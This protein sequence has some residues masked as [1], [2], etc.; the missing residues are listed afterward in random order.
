MIFID[1]YEFLLIFYGFQRFLKLVL[2]MNNPTLR[3]IVSQRPTNSKKISFDVEFSMGRLINKEIEGLIALE[4][5]KKDL[6]FN[7]AD[8]DLK[9]AFFTID[10]T[11]CGFLTFDILQVFFEDQGLFYSQEQIVSL[12][13][14]LD[15]NDDGKASFDEFRFAIFPLDGTV[16]K[17]T[18]PGFNYDKNLEKSVNYDHEREKYLNESEMILE[19]QKSKKKTL[20]KSF[21]LDDRNL[22]RSLKNDNKSFVSESQFT[23][24]CCHKEKEPVLHTD[25]SRFC[26]KHAKPKQDFSQFHF[27]EQG[28]LARTLKQFILL[29]KEVEIMRRD[30][31]IRE[32][33]E[34]L[35]A[36]QIMDYKGKGSLS[37]YE[38]EEA[39]NKLKVFPGKYELFLFIKRFNREVDGKLSFA[40]FV[41]SMVP[42]ELRAIVGKRRPIDENATFDDFSEVFSHDFSFIFS[43]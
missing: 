14:R 29:D 3:T 41:E 35:T 12:L 6:F 10:K 11:N 4:L 13:K 37:A 20:E 31:S 9:E 25:H 30:L 8:F 1:F 24:K 22:E 38:L 36:F 26:R 42:E 21:N 27:K 15:R 39:L 17:I 34:L 16:P 32:D 18:S 2:P 40:G 7:T 28:E 5:K 23:K 19:K 33:F 43:K